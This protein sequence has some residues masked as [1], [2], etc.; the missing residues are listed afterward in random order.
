MGLIHAELG[1]VRTEY[2]Y[3]FY[4]SVSGLQ[5]FIC[6]RFVIHPVDQMDFLYQVVR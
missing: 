1:G 6:V 2:L 3:I 4:C 5:K